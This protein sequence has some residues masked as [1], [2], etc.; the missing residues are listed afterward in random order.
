MIKRKI[1]KEIFVKINTNLIN[2]VE[3][4]VDSV[5]GNKSIR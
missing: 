4:Y 2:M 3:I 5:R 1:K